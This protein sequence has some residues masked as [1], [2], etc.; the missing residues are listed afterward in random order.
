M[1]T[2]VTDEQNVKIPAELARQMQLQPGARLEWSLGEDGVLL[3][4]RVSTRGELVR[5]AFGM[6]RQWLTPAANP[7][8]DLIAA[9]AEEDLDEGR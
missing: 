7:V 2:T 4:R 1:I 9:R 5:K 3:V 8:A 6:G